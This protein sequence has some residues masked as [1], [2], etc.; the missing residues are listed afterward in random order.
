MVPCVVVY[1]QTYVLQFTLRYSV[2]CV[3]RQICSVQQCFTLW[4]CVLA[5]AGTSVIYNS[6]HSGTVCLCIYTD[7]FSGAML[8]TVVLCVGVPV[9]IDLFF[10]LHSASHYGT[11]CWCTSTGRSVLYSSASHCGTEGTCVQIDL[12]C[13]AVLHSVV[14]RVRVYRQ[15]CSAKQCFTL[16]Y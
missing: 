8:H 15:I 9:H 3:Y 10:F 6:S 14:L 4:Y 11:V 12:F 7:L 13:E 1:R 2:F 16:W 5:C